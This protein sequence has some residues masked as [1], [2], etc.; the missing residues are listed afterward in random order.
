MVRIAKRITAVALVAVALFLAWQPLSEFFAIDSCLDSGGSFNYEIHTCDHAVSRPVGSRRSKLNAA[1]PAVP[2]YVQAY[3]DSAG[4]DY[5]LPK[6]RFEPYLS[7]YFEQQ[8]EAEPWAVADDF[9]GD[10]VIDWAG[11]LRNTQGRIDLVVVYSVDTEYSHQLLTP[12]GVDED[13]VYFGVVLEPLGKVIGFPIEDDD[14]VPTL[15][16]SNPGVHLIYYEKASVL[17]YWHDGEFREF[18]TGD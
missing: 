5:V 4:L 7:S 13:G 6:G 18:W 1:P 12:M 17:Y 16:L 10:E 14:P 8:N 15:S 2:A 3:L 11:F 9:N